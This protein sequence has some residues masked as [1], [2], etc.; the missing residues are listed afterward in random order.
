MKY[1]NMYQNFYK[2]KLPLSMFSVDGMSSIFLKD[3]FM[4]IKQHYWYWIFFITFNN[5]IGTNVLQ[6]VFDFITYSIV[7][8]KNC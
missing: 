6:K 5:L 1:V 8:P 2:S 3:I 4:L 7:T